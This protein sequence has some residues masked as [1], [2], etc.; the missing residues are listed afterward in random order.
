MSL[1]RRSFDLKSF[2]IGVIVTAVPFGFVGTAAALDFGGISTSVKNLV[3]IKKNLDGDIK[4]L[5][6]DAKVLFTDKDSLL[7]IKDQLFKLAAETKSQI[8][9]ISKLVAEVETHI[10]KTQ[11]DIG[12]TSNHV[13]EIDGVR[14]ALSGK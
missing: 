1:D 4:Y 2:V 9:S 13:G 7:Q 10:K 5:S 14:K 11:G 6:A 8:E 12:T 3:N